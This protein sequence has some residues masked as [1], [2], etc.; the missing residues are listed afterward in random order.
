VYYVVSCFD[1][2]GEAAA[3]A[4]AAVL[5]AH[6]DYVDQRSGMLML[7]GPL[8]APDGTTRAGQ[9]FV[10]D[11][12]DERAAQRFVDEDPFTTAGIFGEVRIHAFQ[13]RFRDGRRL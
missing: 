7:S 4:R 13:P 1:A 5:P 6:R 11:V 2:E 10:L 12:P 9:L 8:L 3:S